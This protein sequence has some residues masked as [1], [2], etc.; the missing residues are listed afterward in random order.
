[1]KLP[2][3]CTLAVLLLLVAGSSTTRARDTVGTSSSSAAT[4]AKADASSG[5][6]VP[7]QVAKDLDSPAVA[8]AASAPAG[9]PQH[10][11]QQRQGGLAEIRKMMLQQQSE[12]T[13][14][15]PSSSTT[16]QEP[17]KFAKIC[18]CAMSWASACRHTHAQHTPLDHPAHPHLTFLLPAYCHH[19]HHATTALTSSKPLGT[20]INGSAW[21]PGACGPHP[22]ALGYQCSYVAPGGAVLHW[23][24]THDSSAPPINRCTMQQQAIPNLEIAEFDAPTVHFALQAATKVR[25]HSLC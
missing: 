11:Q 6:E 15:E 12:D 25:L 22:T 18:E 14:P 23:T 1:M 9:Q 3:A 2:H 20:A 8:A 7:F 5:D 13:A 10:A 16:K 4:V 19:C 24:Y 17:F 21:Q